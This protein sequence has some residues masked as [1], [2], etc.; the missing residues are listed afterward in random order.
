MTTPKQDSLTLPTGSA[1]LNGNAEIAP[2]DSLLKASVESHGGVGGGP[3][4]PA[5]P[6]DTP[7]QARI[8]KERERLHKRQIEMNNL[9]WHEQEGL[10]TRRGELDAEWETELRRIERAKGKP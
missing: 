4:A 1:L 2:G 7:E 3:A 8:R 9:P 5:K 10:R 6:T